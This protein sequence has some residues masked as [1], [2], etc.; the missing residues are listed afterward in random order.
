MGAFFSFHILLK[1]T[2]SKR[3]SYNRGPIAY[4]MCIEY[5]VVAGDMGSPFGGTQ[6]SPLF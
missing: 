2:G 1:K 6:I 5:N 4:I 3:I